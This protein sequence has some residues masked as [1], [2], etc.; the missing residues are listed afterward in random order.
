M[1]SYVGL[2]LTIASAEQ[3][4]VMRR[5]VVRTASTCTVRTGTAMWFMQVSTFDA[6]I[7]DVDQSAMMRLR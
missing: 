5:R 3:A 4:I 2:A 6:R 7:G 1:Q